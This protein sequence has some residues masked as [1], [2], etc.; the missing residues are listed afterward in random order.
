MARYC[1][2]DLPGSVRGVYRFVGCGRKRL[3]L[4]LSAHVQRRS[5]L[6]LK[7]AIRARLQA[8]ELAVNQVHG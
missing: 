6:R 2:T 4:F 8:C 5:H 3:L 1:A 7:G